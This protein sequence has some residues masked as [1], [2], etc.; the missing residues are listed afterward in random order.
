MTSK[1]LLRYTQ[2]NSFLK[3][4]DV[5]TRFNTAI[6][7]VFPNDINKPELI[8]KV[9]ICSGYLQLLNRFTAKSTMIYL[10]SVQKT[11]IR[12]IMLINA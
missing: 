3:E 2:A 12:F 5:G 1:K 4:F 7:E 10:E 11:K 8:T 6:G 9:L